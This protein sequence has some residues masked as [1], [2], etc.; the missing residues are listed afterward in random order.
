MKKHNLDGD[1]NLNFD[2]YAELLTDYYD[3]KDAQK[4]KFVKGDKEGNI[5]EETKET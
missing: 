1:G 4:N 2:E 3:L 5:A